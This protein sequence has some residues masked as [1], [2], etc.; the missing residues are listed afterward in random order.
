[1]TVGA[2]DEIVITVVVYEVL[3]GGVYVTGLVMPPGTEELAGV[4]VEQSY[5][6]GT[7][8]ETPQ[9]FPLP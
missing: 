2:H 7:P 5:T 6:Y 4:G 8:L 1:M 9:H 3:A